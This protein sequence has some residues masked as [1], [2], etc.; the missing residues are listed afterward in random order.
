M[1]VYATDPSPGPLSLRAGTRFAYFSFHGFLGAAA[2]TLVDNTLWEDN[3]DIS[4]Y[5]GYAQQHTWYIHPNV[6]VP[7]SFQTWTN[8]EIV[9]HRCGGNLVGITGAVNGG[10]FANNYIHNE[11]TDGTGNCGAISSGPTASASGVRNVVIT[12]NRL[13]GRWGSLLSCIQNSEFSNNIV[14]TTGGGTGL[15]V[16]GEDF[17]SGG[18]SAG[19]G[20]TAINVTN[21]TIYN[22][23]VSF[24]AVGS[25]HILRNNGT[26]TSGGGCFNY[27]GNVSADHNYC[28]SSNPSALWVA[29]SSDLRVG[30][31]K[32]VNPGPLVGTGNQSLYS[33]TAI[34]TT[35]WDTTDNGVARS[36]PI[37]IGAMVH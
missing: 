17:D 27:G 11:G 9:V 20:T 25:N 21:N 36:L 1:G 6:E 31:F 28:A 10:L 35:S 7:G 13:K 34:G 29:P 14:T 37:D 3:G 18:C 15:G 19:Y 30:N 23:N 8:N 32:P 26:Y 2:T 4:C 24:A 22:G 5:G 16:G 12:R 33:A